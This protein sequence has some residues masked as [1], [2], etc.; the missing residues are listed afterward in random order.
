MKS[1]QNTSDKEFI[2]NIEQS[3]K[4]LKQGDY[5]QYKKSMFSKE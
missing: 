4:E 2:S 5:Q 1:L 3:L